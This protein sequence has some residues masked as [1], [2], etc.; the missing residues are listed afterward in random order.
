MEPNVL[1]EMEGLWLG[2]FA[3]LWQE[4]YLWG[5]AGGSLPLGAPQFWVHR[6]HPSPA[7]AE[8]FQHRGACPPSTTGSEDATA[9]LELAWWSS[10]YMAVNLFRGHRSTGATLTRAQCHC[11]EGL[12]WCCGASLCLYFGSIFRLWW[13]NAHITFVSSIT[14]M[15][16]RAFVP[17]RVSGTKNTFP[18]SSAESSALHPPC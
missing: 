7:S 13:R 15:P 1:E 8:L 10:E 9:L 12:L 18:K 11:S 5:L 2:G 14:S 17:D 4:Q 16:E 3:F 6:W